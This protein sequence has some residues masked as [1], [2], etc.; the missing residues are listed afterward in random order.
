[1]EARLRMARRIEAHGGHGAG[2]IHYAYVIVLLGVLNTLGAQGFLRFG[3]TMTLPS[4]RQELGLNFTQTGALATANYIGY[5]VAA[6]A[7]GLLVVR[8]GSR[9][10]IGLAA[11]TVGLAM[12]LA[13][14]TRS[15]E[16]LLLLQILAGGAGLLATSPS[17]ALATAWFARRRR[18]LAAGSMSAGAPLGSLVTGLLIPALVLAYGVSGWR[19]GWLL[20]GGAVLV[21]GC[22]GLAFLR[23]RPADVGL[24]PLGEYGEPADSPAGTPSVRWSL[25][26]RSPLVWY[27]GL[28]GLASTLSNISFTTFYASY[29]TRERGLDPET[30][31]RF[32]ALTGIF[33]VAGAFLWGWVSDRASRKFALIFTYLVQGGAFALFALQ[34]DPALYAFCAILFGITSRANYAVMAALCGD[35]LGPRLGVAAFGVNNLFAGVGLALGPTAAGMIAD[36]TSSFVPAFLLSALVAFLGALGSAF[37]HSPGRERLPD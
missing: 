19:Q 17:L 37:L 36:S 2:H 13:G 33:G 31:G 29:L 16:L 5:T 32:W 4:I 23:N 20:L 30:A 8:F 21:V 27:L 34:A 25:V 22:L 28:L 18:G 24:S 12:I 15:Y 1:M 14:L 9:L 35:L 7:V 26:Y 11:S 6:L 10:T 3:Y